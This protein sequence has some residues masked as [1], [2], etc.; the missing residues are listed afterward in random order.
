MDQDFPIGELARRSGVAIETIR[1]YER[2]SLLPRVERTSSGR[3][4]FHEDDLKT[5][6]F[7]RRSRELG[8]SLGDIRELLSLRRN[9]KCSA[10]R[11]IAERHLENVRE[12]VRSLTTLEHTLSDAVARCPGDTSPECTILEILEPVL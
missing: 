6:V 5:L 7:I 10:V 2:M 4:V 8:F 12:K 1:Y 11:A 3:R 9:V